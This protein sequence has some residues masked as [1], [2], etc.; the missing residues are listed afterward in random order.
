MGRTKLWKPVTAC[1]L[2]PVYEWRATDLAIRRGR[3]ILSDHPIAG[4][5]KVETRYGRHIAFAQPAGNTRG[6]VLTCTTR[7]RALALRRR[8]PICG[9]ALPRN[10]PVY[11]QFPTSYEGQTGVFA[12]PGA[13]PMHRSCALYS[14][15]CCPW[16]RLPSARGRKGG[17]L[18]GPMVIR[19]FA[20]FG[21]M[22]TERMVT[23]EE[24]FLTYAYVETLEVIDSGSGWRDILPAYEQS[25]ADEID[26]RTRLHWDDSPEDEQRLADDARMD[27]MTLNELWEISVPFASDNEFAPGER[28]VLI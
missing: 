10:A 15:L 11:R 14:V 5:V 9:C 26:L 13:S 20:T 24:G 6:V 17:L 3:H 1:F 18:R 16:L 2:P 22:L 4:W 28:A 21:L 7:M 12:A 23:G 8:C 25:L 19:G 27:L